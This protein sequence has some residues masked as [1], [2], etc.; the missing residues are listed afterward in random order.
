MATVAASLR[1]RGTWTATSPTQ[2][3]AGLVGATFLA[4]GILGFVPGVT[5]NLSDISFASHHSD[6]KLLGLFQVSVLHNI[7]HA[8]FGVVGI[9]L[10]RRSAT[11]ALW[12]L[13]GGG[14][15]YIVLALFGSAIDL[16]SAI[17]FVPVNHADNWLHLGLGTGMILL[18]TVLA[19]REPQRS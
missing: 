15:V 14:F 1:R 6:A 8:L 4:V 9:P 7:V 17:N 16:D 5:T 10:A 11:S 13:L 12:F 19:S 2:L 3:I 18:G